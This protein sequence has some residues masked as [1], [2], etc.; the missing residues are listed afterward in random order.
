MVSTERVMDYSKL[1]SE[2]DGHPTTGYPSDGWPDKGLIKIT[3][4]YYRHSNNG[5]LV[6]NNINCTIKS[7]EKVC[8]YTCTNEH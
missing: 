2:E 8:W 5:P 1:V 6:L 4:L 7:G 3:D